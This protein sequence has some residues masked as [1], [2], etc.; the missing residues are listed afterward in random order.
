MN[1]SRT[2]LPE[3]RGSARRINEI[4]LGKRA[5]TADTALRLARY[6]ARRSSCGCLQADYDLEEARRQPGGRRQDRTIS[7][8][9][10]LC[11]CSSLSPMDI[12]YDEKEDILF[13]RFNDEALSGCVPWLE[14]QC[15]NDGERH[16]QITILDCQGVRLLRS[17]FRLSWQLTEP[18]GHQAIVMGLQ[19]DY[20]I[21]AARR[22][23][24]G[25]STDRTSAV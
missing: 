10:Q 1:L 14:R 11:L 3:R 21:E 16:W 8:V 2:P 7:G 9:G 15:R 18:R 12:R 4:V 5:I 22:H 20:D 24:D 6:F 25:R 23:L 17:T 13:I 19:A